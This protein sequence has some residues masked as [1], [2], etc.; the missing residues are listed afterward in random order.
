MSSH[1]YRPSRKIQ[2]PERNGRRQIRFLLEEVI[3]LAERQEK[4]A[5]RE[6]GRSN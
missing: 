6:S 4:A 3:A 1:G 2:R 5:E